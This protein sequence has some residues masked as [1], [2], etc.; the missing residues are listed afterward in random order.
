MQPIQSAMYSA[1]NRE[2]NFLDFIEPWN[3]HSF[4]P[5][6][7]KP[8]ENLT[9]FLQLF[10]LSHGGCNN[11]CIPVHVYHKNH[12]TLQPFTNKSLLTSF[13][14]WHTIPASYG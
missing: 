13:Q 4:L 3:A 7:Q 12:L 5:I 10:I 8:H 14:L 1:L 11:Q 2:S 6:A 9:P